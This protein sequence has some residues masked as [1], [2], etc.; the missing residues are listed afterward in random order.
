MEKKVD[1]TVLLIEFL[2][3]LSVIG[4]IVNSIKRTFFIP[5]LSLQ[6]RVIWE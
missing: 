3:S 5:Y 6:F 1:T 2:G 4:T